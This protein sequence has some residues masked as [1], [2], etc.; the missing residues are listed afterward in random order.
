MFSWSELNPSRTEQSRDGHYATAP[1][2]ALR[3]HGPRGV[4][5]DS[6]AS[7]RSPLSLPTHSSGRVA[8]RKGAE[9]QSQGGFVETGR[10]LEPPHR[11]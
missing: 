4:M 5:P 1:Q 11:P 2:E 6:P 10:G 9:G 3:K 8:S 7:V